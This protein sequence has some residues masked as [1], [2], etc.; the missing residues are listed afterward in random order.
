MDKQLLEILL[1]LKTPANNALGFL[2]LIAHPAV[3]GLNAKQREYLADVI[4]SVVTLQ[5]M[6][7][8]LQEVI[9]FSSRTLH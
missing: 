6:I 9:G 3:G 5:D 8:G 4:A 2:E 1:Q 7:D